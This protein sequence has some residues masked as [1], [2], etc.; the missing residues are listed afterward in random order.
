ML[1]TL[2]EARIKMQDYR[3]CILEMMPNEMVGYATGDMKGT[4]TPPWAELQREMERFGQICAGYTHIRR[5]MK[6]WMVDVIGQQ[7]ECDFSKEKGEK[8]INL[9]HESVQ[10]SQEAKNEF[11]ALVGG[12]LAQN[13]CRF[14]VDTVRLSPT[15][16]GGGCSGWH[17]GTPCTDD[18]CMSL[19][20]MLHL[21][22]KKAIDAGL[23]KIQVKFWGWKF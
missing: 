20:N 15:D 11:A 17:I 7:G 3:D 13:V 16:S 19:C 21:H 23:L 2:E 12:A 5:F 14:I 1:M 22:F 10:G 8:A 6:P 4:G 9:L 18:E